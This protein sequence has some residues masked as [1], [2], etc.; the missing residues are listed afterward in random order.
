MQRQRQTSC[1]FEKGGGIR[2]QGSR[3][4]PC[5]FRLLN[6]FV[7]LAVQTCKSHLLVIL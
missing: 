5:C 2:A 4:F 1:R 3:R 7:T 6:L